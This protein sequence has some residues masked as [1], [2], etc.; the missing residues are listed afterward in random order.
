MVLQNRY[1][2]VTARYRKDDLKRQGL[3]NTLCNFFG[4]YM[5]LETIIIQNAYLKNLTMDVLCDISLDM[6]TSFLK[7]D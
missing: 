6:D 2:N 1:A 7:Q 3:Q 5:Y 4:K